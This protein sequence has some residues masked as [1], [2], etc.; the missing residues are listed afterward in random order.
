MLGTVKSFNS[1]KGFG[2]IRIE[3]GD[4]V[5]VHHTAIEDDSKELAKGQQVEFEIEHGPKGATARDVKRVS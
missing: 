5:F 4:D 1:E 2:F 3:D